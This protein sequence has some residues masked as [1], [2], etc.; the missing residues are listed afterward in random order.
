[1]VKAEDDR[2]QSG[3]PVSA[4]ELEARLRQIGAE[5]YH[6]LHPFHQRLH[7]GACSLDEVRAW[8][9]NRYCYQRTIPLKDAAML[10]RLDDIVLRREWRQRLVD[11]D[12]EIDD[13]P[14]GGLRRWLALTDQLGLERDYVVSLNGVLPAV[15][16]ACDA[17][18]RFVERM[19]LLDAIASS[20]TELFSPSIIRERV[21]GMLAHYPFVTADTLR[22]F[23]HRLTEAPRDV[24][25]ALEFVKRHATTAAQQEAACAALRFKCDMLWAQLDAIEHA[26]VA[27]NVP[28]GAWHPDDAAGHAPVDGRGG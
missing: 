20:L 24:S 2:R 6:N 25:F 26:Y 3:E 27:G 1:M 18:V 14:E 22:Y 5:R 28:P 23:E 12:G 15:R 21:T 9:L 16:F 10:A 17:Y 13:A 7:A 11:H 4:D 8:A 19:P